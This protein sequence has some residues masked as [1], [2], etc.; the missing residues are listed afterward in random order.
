MSKSAKKLAAELRASGWKPF[1]YQDIRETKAFEYLSEACG[2]DCEGNKVERDGKPARAE[3]TLG[4]HANGYTIRDLF[5]NLV[6]DRHGDPVGSAFVDRWLNPRNPRRLQEAGGALAAVDS[7]AFAGITGQLMI[8][9]L[10][11]KY[12][13]EEYVFRKMLPT[14]NTALEQE[15][16]PG[17]APP[18]DPGNNVLRVPEGKAFPY[19]G[20][21]E[22]YVQT[23]LTLKEGCI[24][25]LTK[26]AIF[27]DRTGQMVEMAKE[28]GDLLAWNEETEC[29]GTMIGSATD[30]ILF[31][32]K[33]AVD[34]A[35][36]ALDGYQAAGGAASY[37]GAGT[38]INLQT[39]Y[40]HQLADI[41]ASRPYAYVNEVPNNPIV[42]YTSIEK[43]D[44]YFANVVDPNRGRPIVVG[45]PHIIAPYNKRMQIMRVTEAENI[46]QLTQQGITS[47]GA[48]F[49]GSRNIL[50]N[51][52]MT[53]DQVLT[54]R[55]F[56]AEV[57]QQL[58]L[59]SAQADEFWL[60]GDVTKALQYMV[61]WGTML[62]QA[63]VNSEAEFE[64]DV[65]VRWKASKRGR[66]AW[67]EP[68]QVQRVNLVQESGITSADI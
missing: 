68:R 41:A 63:P 61:N 55:H 38:N 16:I 2:L 45:K 37:S 30:Q 3:L 59:T 33:R 23:P 49:T 34:A 50:G 20:F 35:Q 57:V 15:K 51:M 62:V 43:C 1:D 67:K 7:S 53:P 36:I 21:G 18:K 4:E 9:Q 12:D 27:F 11:S 48:I 54:S 60:Y 28:V 6:C 25:G 26:E 47:P 8:T 24:I 40:S 22:Q 46:M 29:I 17:L 13:E 10:L 14:V 42:D 64:Q 5:E 65:I 66:P 58:G 31:T 32:E 19:L 39:A 56:K 52:G 44:Q